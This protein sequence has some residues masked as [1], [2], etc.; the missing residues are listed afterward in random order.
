MSRRF[1]EGGVSY[2]IDTRCGII[3]GGFPGRGVVLFDWGG[4]MCRRWRSCWR[5]ANEL[6]GKQLVEF[7]AIPRPGRSDADF[8]GA[9]PGKDVAGASAGGFVLANPKER[10]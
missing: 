3:G 7:V 2:T 9:V 10:V 5:E 6:A 8:R 1:N 4:T